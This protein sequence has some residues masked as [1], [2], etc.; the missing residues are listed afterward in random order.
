M[1]YSRTPVFVTGW[2]ED[3]K[4]DG[5]EFHFIL[6]GHTETG[7]QQYKLVA[8]IG[9]EVK[10][11]ALHHGYKTRIFL[12]RGAIRYWMEHFPERPYLS[13]PINVEPYKHGTIDRPNSNAEASI[14]T[15]ADVIQKPM[16]GPPVRRRGTRP[17]ASDDPS[18]PKRKPGRPRKNSLED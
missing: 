4:K 3:L 2:L 13:L 5:A 17:K 15:P 6:V 12:S 9:D 18:A 1:M 8:V 7:D 14:L 16:S 11:L 10:E